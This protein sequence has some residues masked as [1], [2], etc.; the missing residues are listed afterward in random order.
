MLEEQ[1]LIW[2][3]KHGSAAAFEEIYLRSKNDLLKLAVVLL[4]DVPAAEYQAG[5]DPLRG[6]G[7]LR[8]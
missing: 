7:V 1:Y 3:F 8:L 4:G 5:I 2:R 6:R